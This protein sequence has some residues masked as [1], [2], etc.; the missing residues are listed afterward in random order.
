MYYATGASLPFMTTTGVRTFFFIVILVVNL[1]FIALALYYIRIEVLKYL[2]PMKN[3]LY[4]KILAFGLT[5]RETFIEKYYKKGFVSRE[6]KYRIED[7]DLEDE[8][9]ADGENNKIKNADID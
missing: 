8:G 6:R 1:L 2:Y 3:E 9:L 7:E 4:F 5:K